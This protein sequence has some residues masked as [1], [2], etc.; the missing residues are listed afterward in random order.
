MLLQDRVHRQSPIIKIWALYVVVNVSNHKSG[1][2]FITHYLLPH[3]II[4]WLRDQFDIRHKIILNLLYNLTIAIS[5]I[6]WQVNLDRKVSLLISRDSILER[7]ELG[8]VRCRPKI[9]FQ[10]L[11]VTDLKPDTVNEV[12]MRVGNP[13]QGLQVRVV[14]VCWKEDYRGGI[15]I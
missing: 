6:V 13:L 7:S 2:F 4:H 15:I 14:S 5:I 12:A 3:R 10:L 1:L 9:L 11:S 8:K